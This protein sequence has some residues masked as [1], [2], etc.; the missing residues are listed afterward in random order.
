MKSLR[1]PG[2]PWYDDD[3]SSVY[4]LVL[5]RTADDLAD[6]LEQR[7]ALLRRSDVTA[8]DVCMEIRRQIGAAAIDD[9][10]GAGVLAELLLELLAAKENS[11]RVV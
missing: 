2:A 3:E 10:L 5:R 8:D 11:R 1:P 9:P 4:P 6:R 7:I